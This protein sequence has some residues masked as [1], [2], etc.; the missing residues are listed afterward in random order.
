M[1]ESSSEMVSPDVVADGEVLDEVSTAVV[2]STEQAVVETSDSKPDAST[3]ESEPAVVVV[4]VEALADGEV[5]S[6][7]ASDAQAVEEPVAVEAEPSADAEAEPVAVEAE[8]S[9]DAEASMEAEPVAVE[10]EPSAKPAVQARLGVPYRV[11]FAL[12]SMVAG[13]SS[14]CIKQL[15]LPL[16]VSGMVAAKSVNTEFALV[17]SL[18]ALAGLLAAPIAGALSDRTI[19]RFGR[20]KPWI[21]I[22]LIVALVGLVIMALAK[23]IPV[24]LIGEI[25]EQIGVDGILSNISALIPDQLPRE[26]QSVTASLNGI[27]PNVG[28]VIGLLLVTNFTDTR[29]AMQGYMLLAVLTLIFIGY[30]LL[31]L[32]EPSHLHEKANQ[33]PFNLGSFLVGFVHPLTS[34]DFV[35]TLVSRLLVFFSFTM[36]GSYTLFY[37]LADLHVTKVVAAHGVTTYQLI[38][39]SV[40]LVVAVIAGMLSHRIK[41]LKPF[42]IVGAIL[43]AIGL[44]IIVSV[45]TWTALFTA[46]A[47]FGCGFGSYLG[48]DIALAVRVLPRAEDRGKDL[49]II[50]TAIFL[51]LIVTPLIGAFILNTFHNNYSMLFSVAAVA[52]ILAALFILPIK[53]VR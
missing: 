3:S 31:V 18:G 45:H 14:I 10:A 44:F 11:G 32:R 6:D 8:P 53:S 35:F 34:A 7:N 30:F 49:G 22:G 19:S 25:L 50:Y 40:L 1:A 4:A 16:Q 12:A 15:L 28:G 46:G 27:G 51:P 52:S 29:N 2:E 39:T 13:L 24:L 41:R 48:V 37:L 20:R 26:K 43:M 42:V 33:K 23:T 21:T 38:S 17:S 36:L 9:A 47:I 5:A